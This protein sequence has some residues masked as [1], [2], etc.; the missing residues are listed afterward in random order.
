[1]SSP[2]FESHLTQKVGGGVGEFAVRPARA[3]AEFGGHHDVFQGVERRHELEVLEHEPRVLVADPRAGVLVEVVQG[4]AIEDHRP[5]RG[6]VESGAETE[7]RGLAA[8]R[9]TDDGAGRAGQ[10][11][12]KLTS[13]STVNSRSPLR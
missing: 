6:P 8:A 10:P 7:Q 9:W 4:D 5:T 3:G 12:L 11:E 2:G 1:M 13:L